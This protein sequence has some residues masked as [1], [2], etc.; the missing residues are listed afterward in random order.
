MLRPGAFLGSRDLTARLATRI[1]SQRIDWSISPFRLRPFT[2][3]QQEAGLSF[4]VPPDTH[5]QVRK[6]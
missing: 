5:M 6:Y 4:C 3:I 2:P 1:G